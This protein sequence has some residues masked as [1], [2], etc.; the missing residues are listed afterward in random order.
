MSVRSPVRAVS[1]AEQRA[2]GERLLD[3]CRRA[4]HVAQ[5]V[6]LGPNSLLEGNLLVALFAKAWALSPWTTGRFKGN[7]RRTEPGRV[8]SGGPQQFLWDRRRGKRRNQARGG[9][10]RCSYTTRSRVPGAGHH[11]AQCGAASKG[12]GPER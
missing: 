3:L 11:G 1:C 6:E 9:P 12:S 7:R 5:A 10:S 2:S 8:P 4:N